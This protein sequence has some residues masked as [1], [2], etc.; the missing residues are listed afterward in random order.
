MNSTVA[1]PERT[2]VSSIPRTAREASSSMTRHHCLRLF[3][4]QSRRTVTSENSRSYPPTGVCTPTSTNSR[5]RARTLG[6]SRGRSCCRL[7]SGRGRGGFVRWRPLPVRGSRGFGRRD[8]SGMSRRA[9]GRESGCPD[10][11]RCRGNP[12]LDAGPDAD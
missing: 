4:Y 7:R 12:S 5:S 10:F 11:R 1:A 9:S 6:G 3:W 8:G 2:S